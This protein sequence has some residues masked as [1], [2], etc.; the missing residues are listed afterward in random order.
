MASEL[1]ER[2][3]WLPAYVIS[4]QVVTTI[5]LWIRIG[6]RLAGKSTSGLGIDDFLIVIAWILGTTL[7][8]L[9]VLGTM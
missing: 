3:A 9:A 4:I 8:A 6:G 5:L 7:A 2:R 1:I